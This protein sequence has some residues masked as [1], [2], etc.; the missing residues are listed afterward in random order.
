MPETVLLVDDEPNILEVLRLAIEREGYRVQTALSA[1]AALEALAD[2]PPDVMV[3][4]LKM[5]GIDGRELLRRVRDIRPETPVVLMTAHGTIETAVQA[6]KQGAFD[7]LTKPIDNAALIEALDKALNA[8]SLR[9]A[10]SSAGAMPSADAEEA[11]FLGQS[12]AARALLATVERAAAVDS[13]VLL[14]GETGTGKELIARMLHARGPRRGGPFQAVNCAA[15]PATLIESE[16]FGYEKGA[17]T[18]AAAAK[19]GRF[20][21]ADGGTILLDEIGE[22]PL[23]L[24]PKLLRVLQDQRFERVGGVKSRQVDAR[25]VAATNRDLREQV[26]EG[27]FRE[28]LFYRLNVI[29]LPMPPL[30]ERREDIPLLAERF[31]QQLAKRFGWPARELAGEAR[32]I[33]MRHDWPGNVRELQNLIERLTVLEPAGPITGDA[34][35]RELGAAARPLPASMGIKDQVGAT[36][37]ALETQMIRKALEENDGNRTHA[38]ARLGI[39]RRTLQLKMKRYGMQ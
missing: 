38:A 37:E 3:T 13:T 6:M 5:P 35:A 15:R 23:E 18:G 19:P 4:D 11:A 9:D 21:L 39:S 25:V 22:M 16:L 27:L 2:R 29:T 24:Q 12:P 10:D 26:A 7:Y 33:L 31:C 32:E 14:I 30:R 20:E 1:A 34:V 36:S 8:R 28:D 17:F